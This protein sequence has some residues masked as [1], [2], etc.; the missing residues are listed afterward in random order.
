METV[1]Q[2]LT[3]VQLTIPSTFTI[4]QDTGAQDPVSTPKM[5]TTTSTIASGSQKHHQEII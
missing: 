2:R 3:E 4:H 5:E 1:K